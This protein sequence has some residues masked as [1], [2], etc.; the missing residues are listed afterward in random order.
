MQVQNKAAISAN[1]TQHELVQEAAER[2]R[3]EDNAAKRLG[4]VHDQ[5]ANFISPIS[6]YLVGQALPERTTFPLDRTEHGG[7]VVGLVL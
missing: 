2:Q 6:M 4:R 5:Q 3:Q 1:A 7:G